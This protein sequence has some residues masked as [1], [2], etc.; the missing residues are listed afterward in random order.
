MAAR[1]GP[2]MSNVRAMVQVSWGKPL[3]QLGTALVSVRTGRGAHVWGEPSH[4][5]DH[6]NPSGRPVAADAAAVG[7]R[8]PACA[9][10]VRRRGRGTLD[11]RPGAETAS[12]GRRLPD[13]GRPVRLRAGHPGAMH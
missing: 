12:G 4:D 7:A 5:H 3:G 9:G 1:Y 2:I 13:L 10:D 8:P 11:Y 6:R